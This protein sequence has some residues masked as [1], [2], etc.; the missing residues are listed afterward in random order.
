LSQW[1]ISVALVASALLHGS[2]AIAQIVSQSVIPAPPERTTLDKQN[3][4]VTT[5]ALAFSVTELSIGSE[6]Y[7]LTLTR[8]LNLDRGWVDSFTGQLDVSISGQ[9]HDIVATT[10]FLGNRT[11]SFQDRAGNAPFEPGVTLQAAGLG[12]PPVGYEVTLQDGTVVTYSRL[13]PPEYYSCPNTPSN[14]DACHEY[15]YATNIAYPNGL[16]VK[17]HY[18]VFLGTLPVWHVR[19]QSVTSNAG[20]QIK[21]NYQSNTISNDPNTRQPWLTRVS[22]IAVNSGVEFCDPTADTCSFSGSWPQVSYSSSSGTHTVTD[23]LNRSTQYSYSSSSF[24]VRTPGN[25]TDNIQYGIAT[26]LNPN[27]SGLESRVTSLTIGSNT[28]SY[29]YSDTW[30]ARTRII[31]A[32]DPL[33]KPTIYSSSEVP[34]QGYLLTTMK[35]PLNRSTTLTLPCE[36]YASR[37]ETITVP[38]GNAAVRAC[39]VR[40]NVTSVTLKSKPGS[41]F[42]EIATTSVFPSLC[43][44]RKTCNQPTATIDGRLAQT[45]YTYDPTHG[46]L[47]NETLPAP[48]PNGVRPQKRHSYDQFYAYV[49]NSS[50]G[51]VQAA[52]PVWLP[53]RVS[54]CRTTSSCTNG[55]DEVVTQFEYGAEGTVNRLLLRGKVVTAGGVSL[56]TCYSYDNFGNKVSETTPRAGRSVCP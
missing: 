53:T 38:E 49:R 41:G 16:V 2:H 18:R 5:G 19:I 40:G 51:L 4:N 52:T 27:T 1:R 48:V 45:D 42:G 56:R 15:Y 47:L 44:N 17:P 33:L 10:A 11:W 32:T 3:V 35:D 36:F 39:D 25:A 20:Y 34:P 24:R 22:A 23:S 21:F 28:W 8:Y 7:G 14:G 37:V 12:L 31:T 26:V 9:Y 46:G 50:G 13:A 55:S 6:P 29:A 54:E 43:T 30:S